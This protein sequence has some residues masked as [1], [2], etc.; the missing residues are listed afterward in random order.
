M[1]FVILPIVIVSSL[2][3]LGIPILTQL[4]LAQSL[5]LNKTHFV[6]KPSSRKT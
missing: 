3:L 4:S 5:F 6:N 2:S 1:S